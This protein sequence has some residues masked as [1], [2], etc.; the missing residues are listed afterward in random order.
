MGRPAVDVAHDSLSD[1]MIDVVYSSAAGGGADSPTLS[2][3]FWT[4]TSA[5]LDGA[6]GAPP[7]AAAD[8][9]VSIGVDIGAG[10]DGYES[11]SL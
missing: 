10:C 2:D 5:T 4:E 7:A 6:E 11:S 3:S 1:E 9:F 8:G